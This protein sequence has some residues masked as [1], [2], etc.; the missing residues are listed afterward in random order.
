VSGITDV[1]YIGPWPAFNVSD[2]CITV[3]VILL[4]Y[5]ILF[6]MPKAEPK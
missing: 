4:A 5:A 6:M 3:G 1:I 2:S